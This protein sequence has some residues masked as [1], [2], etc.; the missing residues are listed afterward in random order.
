MNKY[1]GFIIFHLSST[2]QF[3]WMLENELFA[4]TLLLMGINDSVLDQIGLRTL[5]RNDLWSKTEVPLYI[6]MPTRIQPIIT[7]TTIT[8]AHRNPGYFLLSSE[9]ISST[10]QIQ[11]MCIVQ[12]F[13]FL[14]AP[15]TEK[16]Q[17]HV[18]EIFIYLYVHIM[19]DTNIHMHI[20]IYIYIY[21]LVFV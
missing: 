10:I 3:D 5:C 2:L 20:Y 8:H 12:L 17:A 11:K 13:R 1:F 7:H 9:L 21:I 18:H 6:S 15:L 16:D 4:S 19:M 14:Y